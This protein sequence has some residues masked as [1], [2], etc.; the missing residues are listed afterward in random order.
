MP[1]VQWRL[2]VQVALSHNIR[3]FAFRTVLIADDDP[4]LLD[5][6]G[7][8]FRKEGC[9]VICAKDGREAIEKFRA[10]NFHC[11]RKLYQKVNFTQK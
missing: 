4:Q 9:K 10:S 1:C 3:S 5:L 2:I 7:F 8:L 11:F 6:Y